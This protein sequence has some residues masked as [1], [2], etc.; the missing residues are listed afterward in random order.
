MGDGEGDVKLMCGEDDRFFVVVEKGRK[1]GEKLVGIRDVKKGSGLMKENDRSM[2]W[3][4]R[5][6]D[7]RVGLGMGDFMDGGVWIRVDWEGDEGLD[8]YV[9]MG[10]LDGGYGV[11]IRRRGYG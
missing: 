11:G 10:V 1:E 4:W 9:V 7:E 3:E 2:V 5:R 8:E 6:N